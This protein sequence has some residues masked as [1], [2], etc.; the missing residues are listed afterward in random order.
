[1]KFIDKPAGCF[2]DR[3]VSDPKLEPIDVIMMTLDAEN[4]LEKSLYTVYRE[5]PVKRLIV[6]DGGSKDS[7]I[8][9]LENFPRTEIHIKS[10]YKTGAKSLE[11]LILQVKTDWF[12]LIDSD[13]E[14]SLGWYDEMC[15]NKEKYDAIEN[16]ANYLAYHKY[17]IN[18]EKLRVG[19]RAGTQCHLLKTK[20]LENFHCDDDFMWRHTDF[21]MQQVIE[22]S[23]FKYGKVNSVYH[24]HNETERIPYASDISKAYRIIV[25]E[26]PK[27]IILDKRKAQQKDLDNARAI[28]KYLDPEFHL[29]KKSPGFDFVIRKLDRDWIKTINPKWI[30]RYDKTKS[31]T[32]SLKFLIYK[33]I[34]IKNRRIRNYT[35]KKYG[36]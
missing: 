12:V 36:G 29:V 6:C 17:K 9:I 16:G 8:K 28:I 26:E 14:L 32:S 27:Y 30:K 21:L 1:L 11:F 34:I 20:S 18:E 4:F 22:Q 23:G 3:S 25:I 2:C 10:E 33:Y 31:L 35:I 7:T 5:I 15:K 13:I 24:V 19:T